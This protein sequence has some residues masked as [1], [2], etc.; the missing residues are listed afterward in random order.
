MG[1]AAVVYGKEKTD[2]GVGEICRGE[3]KGNKREKGG[4]HFLHVAE[5][6]GKVCWEKRKMDADVV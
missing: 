4:L 3:K 2:I 1:E 6:K 5:E